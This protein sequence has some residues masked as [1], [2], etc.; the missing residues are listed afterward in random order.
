MLSLK[1]HGNSSG[2][3]FERLEAAHDCCAGPDW[4]KHWV[5]G[6]R[7]GYFV[8]AKVSLLV[9]KG[10]GDGSSML[11]MV[12]VMRN[13]LVV[14]IAE[15]EIPKSERFC[16]TICLLDV[17]VFTALHGKEKGQQSELVEGCHQR[18]GG[19]MHHHVLQHLQQDG[20]LVFGGGVIVFV[21]SELPL[22]NDY[23]LAIFIERGVVP[24]AC[25][26]GHAC[27]IDGSTA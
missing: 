16:A 5:A 12:T 20:F 14:P 7:L 15:L 23:S 21:S 17:E 26:E 6:A 8:I 9:L 22:Q 13:D 24:T 11:Q 2:E 25:D 4:A 27:T 19:Q 1:V 18:H 3:A 10:D